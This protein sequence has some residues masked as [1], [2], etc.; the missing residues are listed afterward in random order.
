MSS[1]LETEGKMLNFPVENGG[2]VRPDLVRRTCGGWLAVA[3]NQA[4]FS[5]A[6]TA[7]THECASEKFCFVYKRWLEILEAK[8]LDVPNEV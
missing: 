5:I 8:S 4:K 1:I 2:E 7:A 6:V 3:P